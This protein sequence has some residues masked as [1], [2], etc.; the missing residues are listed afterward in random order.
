MADQ[1]LIGSYDYRLVILSVFI[2]VLASYTALDL[3]ERITASRGMYRF[4]WLTGG[5]ISMGSGIWSMHYAGMLAFRLPVPIQYDWPTVLLSL[6]VGILSS[7][8]ALVVVSRETMG[9]LRAII[10]SLFMGGA[11]VALHYIA[12]AAMRLAA[13]CHYSPL[14][15][16]VSVVLAIAGSWMAL[17]LAFFFRTRPNRLVR[18]SASAVL[19]GSAIAGM[20]Y[21]AMAAAS[22][23]PSAAP[24]DLSHAVTVSVLGIAGISGVPVMVLVLTLFTCLADRLEEQRTFLDKLFEEAPEAIALAAVRQGVLRINRAFTQVFGYTLAEVKGRLIG[25]LIVPDE[26]KNEI[27]KHWALVAQGRRVDYESA[28]RRKDG[29]LLDVAVI[30]VPFELPNQETAVYAMYRE[31]TERKQAETALRRERDRAQRYLDVA[32]VILL[33]LD[34]EGRIT[35]INR[36]GCSML[37]WEEHELL[38]RDWIEMCLPARIRN[39]LRSEFRDLLAGDLSAIENPVVTRSGEERLI[40]WR[41]TLVRDESGHIIGTL[42][43]GEDITERKRADEA[44]RDLSGQLLRSQDEE[45]RRLARELHDSTGQKL[46]A[47]AMNLGAL[48]QSAEA[49][50]TRSQRVLVE[51]L[52]LAEDCLREMRTLAYL[53]HPPELDELGLTDAVRRYVSGFVDRSG[54][55]VDL[56][57][58]SKVGRLPREV[59]ITL[60]R[61]LQE[62]LNNVLRHSGSPK[63]SVHIFRTA[64]GVTMKVQDEGHGMHGSELGPSGILAIKPGVGIAGMRERVAQIG[65]RLQIESTK[66]GTTVMAVL[67]LKGHDG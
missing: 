28:H 15:V 33:A 36:K 19:M 16:A 35:L 18:K 11:I 23:T 45:R 65:G 34:L 24:S 56:E 2:A 66:K 22:F 25:D 14:L 30:L 57:L 53:L 5:C 32:E 8:A 51:S 60:F 47:L 59:K 50:D 44:L 64:D 38:G 13:M 48:S 54:I 21:T 7:L 6:L 39:S 61:I 29:S 9:P 3:G 40:A 37:G 63:A 17:W 4:A 67:P 42:S 49:L 55:A 1:I 31:I 10:G 41:N 12:M 46:A 20:H 26:F 43:S 62:S 52:A 58:C 27:K